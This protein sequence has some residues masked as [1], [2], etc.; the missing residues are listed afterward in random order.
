MS[1]WDVQLLNLL[2]A[3]HFRGQWTALGPFSKQQLWTVLTY[4]QYSSYIFKFKYSVCPSF[5]IFWFYLFRFRGLCHAESFLT[6]GLTWIYF[7][8]IHFRDFCL[9]PYTM[10]VNVIL[11]RRHS[12]HWKSTF[13]KTLRNLA[14]HLNVPVTL[15]HP[16]KTHNETIHSSDLIHSSDPE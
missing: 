12:Q 14:S 2:C 10:K 4:T 11:F 15:D 13:K 8:D 6:L 7:W 9:H 16:R 3:F 5:L 1:L